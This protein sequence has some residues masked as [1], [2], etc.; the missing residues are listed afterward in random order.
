MRPGHVTDKPL[1]PDVSAKSATQ[2][3][4]LSGGC[5]A[6]IGGIGESVAKLHFL[7]LLFGEVEAACEEAHVFAVTHQ[8][9][10]GLDFLDG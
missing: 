3:A 7:Q 10:A 4:P 2:I 6:E 8:E 5:C 9:F 1:E